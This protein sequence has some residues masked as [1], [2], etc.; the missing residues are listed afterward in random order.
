MGG[1]TYTNSK[2]SDQPAQLSDSDS[3]SIMWDVK[4]LISIC[5][6][7]SCILSI[8][9]FAYADNAWNVVNIFSVFQSCDAGCIYGFLKLYHLPLIHKEM[10]QDL[11]EIRH[12]SIL[13][14][15]LRALLISSCKL[16]S[17]YLFILFNLFKFF[18]FILFRFTNTAHIS[19]CTGK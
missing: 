7:I 18:Y 14:E 13:P 8:C 5:S 6:C 9:C 3:Q 19:R 17:C 11:S 15:S 2:L 12:P 16:R 10:L 4:T 1:N